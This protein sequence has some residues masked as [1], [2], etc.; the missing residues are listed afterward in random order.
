MFFSFMPI[1]CNCLIVLRRLLRRAERLGHQENVQAFDQILDP[2][3]LTIGSARRLATYKRGD[4]LLSQPERLISLVTDPDRPLQII[5]A[6]K[7]H[8]RDDEGKKILQRIL[9]FGNKPELKRRIV[10]VEDYDYN[11]ARH[12]VQAEAWNEA[13]QVCH[14]ILA[15]DNCWEAAYRLLMRVHAAQDNRPQVHSIYQRCVTT[16][17]EELDVEPSPTTQALYEHLA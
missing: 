9:Q 11:V 7:A 16:L 8:P 10:F 17:R 2:D 14:L 12:L 13:G 5:F 6:G 4:L 15:R 1:S 3:I